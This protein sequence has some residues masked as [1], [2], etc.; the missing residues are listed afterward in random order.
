MLTDITLDTSSNFGR[1]F[2]NSIH[3]SPPGE[4]HDPIR[5]LYGLNRTGK[6]S[7]LNVINAVFREGEE[8]NYLRPTKL[9]NNMPFN[10]SVTHEWDE[11]YPQFIKEMRESGEARSGLRE[12]LKP[13]SDPI[14]F[15]SRSGFNKHYD[16][17]FSQSDLE[18]VP[19]LRNLPQHCEG[20]FYYE[21]D[22]QIHHAEDEQDSGGNQECLRVD[23]RG[24]RYRLTRQFRYEKT[25]YRRSAKTRDSRLGL[26]FEFGGQREFNRHNSEPSGIEV[27]P[28]WGDN[29]R[30]AI[31]EGWAP[32]Y[33]NDWKAAWN[34]QLSCLINQTP[35]SELEIPEY[36]TISDIK[37]I[38]REIR[39]KEEYPPSLL[40]MKGNKSELER[41]LEDYYKWDFVKNKREVQTYTETQVEGDFIVM[42]AIDWRITLEIALPGHSFEET[43]NLVRGMT[44]F[45]G[46]S[47]DYAKK[48]VPE[49]REL[50]KQHGLSSS[51]TKVTLIKRLEEREK[52]S[53]GDKDD[54]IRIL[55]PLLNRSIT[56]SYPLIKG[57]KNG[58]YAVNGFELIHNFL[59]WGDTGSRFGKSRFDERPEFL[60]VPVNGTMYLP[61]DSKFLY[62]TLLGI[63]RVAVGSDSNVIV[64][65]MKESA[66][67]LK[68]KIDDFWKA[69]PNA[70]NPESNLGR[71]IDRVTELVD[72]VIIDMTRKNKQ[73]F[74][75]T[76]VE[77]IGWD[78]AQYMADTGIEYAEP[79]YPDLFLDRHF[80]PWTSGTI[81]RAIEDK[82]PFIGKMIGLMNKIENNQDDGSGEEEGIHYHLLRALELEAIEILRSELEAIERA[83]MFIEI[84]YELS[85]LKLLNPWQDDYPDHSFMRESEN[86]HRKPGSNI[87]REPNT[88]NDLSS[89][90]RQ[91]FSI[92]LPIATATLADRIATDWGWFQ[93][94][95][96]S[97]SPRAGRIIL[98]D[99]PEIS[100]HL[101]WQAELVGM[102]EQTLKNV[103]NT[104]SDINPEQDVIVILATHSPEISGKHRHR[105][106]RMG[107]KEDEY[108]P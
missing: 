50:L 82:G 11:I 7:I 23:R 33:C 92:L 41:S 98:I 68:T 58:L 76:T 46:D 102:I 24:F 71:A 15:L 81:Q 91:L 44:S 6:T 88:A 18:R 37:E 30:T 10:F 25:H 86:P 80:V 27:G 34:R 96:I 32:Y 100:L 66:E 36:N 28:L 13:Q 38:I 99:E 22:D 95:L 40:S 54:I 9:L 19:G 73:S 55:L 84:A 87:D 45:L 103:H 53:P 106:C 89:G 12:T 17:E 5:I 94:E 83:T 56:W 14:E 60:V 61:Y 75:I 42:K 8:G 79:H 67:G 90:E 4:E 78:E 51:G 104:A 59:G 85:N 49:L 52:L 108:V 65:D 97:P 39:L 63:D 77:H 74:R 2:R 43:A 48:T 31:D 47:T 20:A 101:Q 26:M 105:L 72:K 62:S 29:V 57:Q 70:E 16:L 35:M 64:Q 3:F 93:A 1:G 107:P 69:F 21:G